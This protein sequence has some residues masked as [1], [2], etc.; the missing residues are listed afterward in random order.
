MW[1]TRGNVPI[2]PLWSV[3]G[4]WKSLKIN[5]CISISTRCFAMS[6][7]RISPLWACKKGKR[8][9][10][11]MLVSQADEK[12][13]KQPPPR[14]T[15]LFTVLWDAEHTSCVWVGHPSGLGVSEIGVAT[16]LFQM[17]TQTW[18]FS[19]LDAP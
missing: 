2:I 14:S 13:Q 8:F 15:L 1:D 9:G 10:N 11:V 3:V 19:V 12:K 6:D 17:K 18:W 7:I 16:A 4:G 5:K